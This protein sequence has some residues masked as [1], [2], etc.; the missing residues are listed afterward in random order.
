MAGYDVSVGVELLSGLLGS[1]ESMEKLVETVL[2]HILQAQVSEAPVGY[3]NGARQR[4]LCAR[5]GPVTLQVP[6][7]RHTMYQA[8]G[9]I[10]P[11]MRFHPTLHLDGGLRNHTGSQARSTRSGGYNEIS[12]VFQV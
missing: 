6:R 4:T 7:R 2:N 1:Q 8:T 12:D 3:R 9:A 5:V 11:N 10:C